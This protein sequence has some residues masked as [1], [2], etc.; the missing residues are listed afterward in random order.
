MY[1]IVTTMQSL[2]E[3]HIPDALLE[4]LVTDP[5]EFPPVCPIIGGILGQVRCPSIFLYMYKCSLPIL[6]YNE[7]FIPLHQHFCIELLRKLS[8]QYQAKESLSRIS[9]S[10]MQ[11]MERE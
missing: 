7:M 11:W 6:K 4:R 5:R 3:S 1:A 2:K 8:K 9:S 10:L